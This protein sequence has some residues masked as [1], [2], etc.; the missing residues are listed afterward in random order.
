MELSHIKELLQRYLEGQ[1]TPEEELLIEQWFAQTGELPAVL[2]ADSKEQLSQEMLSVIRERI[3][4][5]DTAKAAPVKRFRPWLISA[6]AIV[7]AVAA[8]IY[9][10]L[11][12]AKNNAVAVQPKAVATPAVIAKTVTVTAGRQLKKVLLPDSS[13]VWLNYSSRLRYAAAFTGT[14]REVYLEEGEAYFN[15]RQNAAQPFIVHTANV[16]TRVLG[17]SFNVSAYHSLP[18]IS[19]AVKTGKVRVTAHGKK[20][21][22]SFELLPSQGIAVNPVTL[23]GIAFEQPV[24]HISSWRTGALSFDQAPLGDIILALQNKY[25]VHIS[26]QNPGLRSLACTATFTRNNSLKEILDALTLVHNLQ[27]TINGDEVVI[28]VQEG[29]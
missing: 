6:A 19:V 11:P 14:T 8:G 26:V 9:L 10:L 25:H 7:A 16:D 2:P 24:E 27:Y 3:G 18:R 13:E 20:Q 21:T 23:K 5:P 22:A 1:A 4:L 15:V 28:A 17:T 29:Q 12:A